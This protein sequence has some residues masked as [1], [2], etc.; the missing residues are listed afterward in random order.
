MRIKHRASLLW[1]GIHLGSGF[2]VELTY[3]KNVQVDGAIIGLNDDYDL[4]VPLARFLALNQDLIPERLEHIE[5]TLS[6]YR[7]HH[8][9]E[10]RWKANVLTYQFLSYVYNRPHN[11]TDLA[12]NCIKF[13]RDL[14]VR[15]L[16]IGGEA[17]FQA[18]YERLTVVSQT[19]AAVW[20]YI[21]WVCTSSQYPGP[22]F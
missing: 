10:C 12:K 7:H 3:A 5:D 11:P 6:S 16:M 4:T 18:A 17:V 13:E 15:Q 20:W 14:R 8:R 21:F 9:K 2:D 19:E 1:Q 22:S